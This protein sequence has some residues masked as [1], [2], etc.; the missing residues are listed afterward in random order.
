MEWRGN[1]DLKL[2]ATQMKP[3]RLLDHVAEKMTLRYAIP[4]GEGRYYTQLFT[5]DPRA[6]RISDSMS[7]RRGAI[8][9]LRIVGR[10]IPLVAVRR[11]VTTSNGTL[12]RDREADYPRAP[13]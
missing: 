1:R 3:V 9:T 11:S 10:A 7:E 5:L 2:R 12:N 6:A 8:S 13:T 4:A